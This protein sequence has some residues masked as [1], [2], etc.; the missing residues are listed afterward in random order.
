MFASLFTFQCTV[1]GEEVGNRF[2]ETQVNLMLLE[3][4][5]TSVKDTALCRKGDGLK[6]FF[7]EQSRESL[8]TF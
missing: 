5:E 2:K 3:S 8:H 4:L 7:Y 1:W 6:F